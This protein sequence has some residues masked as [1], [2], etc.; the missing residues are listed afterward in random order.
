[1][2]NEKKMFYEK[3]EIKVYGDLKNITKG[4]G[5]T[6]QSDGHGYQYSDF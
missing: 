1:M 2:D 4:G 5:T 6:G 3:P